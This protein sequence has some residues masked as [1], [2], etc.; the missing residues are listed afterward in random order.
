M[1]NR[2]IQ[3]VLVWML[4]V[5]LAVSAFT[6]LITDPAPVLEEEVAAAQE[7]AAETMA[8]LQM[9]L[10]EKQNVY[11]TILGDSIA[12]GYSKDKSVEI[13]PYGNLVMEALASEGNFSYA[14]SNYGKNGLDSLR[15]NTMILENENVCASLARA[16]VIF[17]TV[18]SNDLLNEF[19]SVVREILD[20]D[21]TFKS[22]EEA[23][24]V[25]AASVA[26]NPMLILNV[27]E[28]IGDWDYTSFENNWIQ[29]MEKICSLKKE[30]AW[31][32][33]TNIYNPASKLEL[34]STMNRVIEEIIRNM[35]QIMEDHSE[36]YGYQ[37]A[38]VFHSDVYEHV[39]ADGVHPDQEGQHMIADCILVHK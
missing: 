11:A 22:V 23:T 21:A 18:G 25:L 4:A 17:I 30:D 13:I 32:V 15:M 35:N 7:E 28:A 2:L 38:D 1:R 8:T 31:I 10:E 20:T 29:M 5:A 19:K 37:V 6:I 36:T 12:K 33:V 16:D 24:D 27:I 9:T 3:A 34:P 14:I 39:Q 26:E